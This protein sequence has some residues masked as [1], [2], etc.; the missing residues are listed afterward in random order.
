MEGECDDDT[1][2]SEVG[3]CP[4]APSDA[5]S[6]Q[7]APEQRAAAQPPQHENCFDWPAVDNSEAARRR[8]SCGVRACV[9]PPLRSLLAR[10]AWWWVLRNSHRSLL[11]IASFKVA[12]APNDG[13]SRWAVR[14]F[15]LQACGCWRRARERGTYLTIR[16]YILRFAQGAAVQLA[17]LSGCADATASVS[18]PGG[19]WCE[20]F[21]H[22]QPAAQHRPSFV[23]AAAAR[24]RRNH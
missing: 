22:L 2:L 14:R 18:I 20:I 13:Q 11:L 8:P 6:Q 4:C 21:S 9:T 12:G 15:L 1:P 5:S 10:A 19:R 16:Y 17:R 24:P 7:Q 23:A 3:S